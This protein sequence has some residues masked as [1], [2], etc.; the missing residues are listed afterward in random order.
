[1]YDLPCA[2][3]HG[4]TCVHLQAGWLEPDDPYTARVLPSTLTWMVLRRFDQRGMV[5]GF[6]SQTGEAHSLETGKK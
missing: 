5:L 6:I 1:M 3:F 2:H 4:T